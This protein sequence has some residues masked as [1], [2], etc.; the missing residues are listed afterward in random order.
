MVNLQDS[1]IWIPNIMK[2]SPPV[3]KV[4]LGNI[5]HNWQ[6]YNNFCS[7]DVDAVIKAN[8]YS[9]GSE[10]IYNT[11]IDAGCKRFWVATV[12]EAITLRKVNSNP[13]ISVL[14][15]I[16]NNNINLYKKYNLQ[17]V[18]NTP[19]Q[20]EIWKQNNDLNVWIHIDTGM[21]RLG[22]SHNKAIEILKDIPKPIGYVSHLS[23]STEL[24]NPFNKIQVD[25]FEKIIEQLPK[26]YTSMYNSNGVIGKSFNQKHFAR[27]GIGLYAII[28]SEFN[29]K[30][31]LEL[32]ASII[33]IDIIEKGEPIGYNSTFIAD[34]KTKIAVVNIG[35]GDGFN[36]NMSNKGYLYHNKLRFPVLG[37]VSMDVIIID[38]TDNNDFKTGDEITI[39]SSCKYN[40]KTDIIDIIEMSNICNVS[41]HNIIT[42]CRGRVI[43]KYI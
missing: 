7:G 36:A 31:V 41:P 3:L 8:A 29:L 10:Q 25:R 27:I 30:P 21:N 23:S 15:G 12:K 20:L 18:I 2:I 5:K 33:K 14:E 19:E 40:E 37:L 39:F 9:I 24:D 4:N 35:Y 1:A 34:K 13:E 26:A 16:A 43:K 28:N 17:G 32:S 11:L 22:I 42:N 6:Q 38:I